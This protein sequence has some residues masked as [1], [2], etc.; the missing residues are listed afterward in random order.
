MSSGMYRLVR[1]GAL[2]MT[3]L[4][5]IG[6]GCPR[7]RPEDEIGWQVW[8]IRDALYLAPTVENTPAGGVLAIAV[9]SGTR[10][11]DQLGDRERFY[12]EPSASALDGEVW[13]V[14]GTSIADLWPGATRQF[15]LP[16]SS[17]DIEAH[18]PDWYGSGLGTIA[19]WIDQGPALTDIAGGSP[20]L[21]ADQRIFFSSKDGVVDCGVF[22]TTDRWAADRRVVFTGDATIRVIE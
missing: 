18:D 17:V 19:I 21:S 14:D 5:L 1:L 10:D 12:G 11:P 8:P 16:S 6:C 22:T 4:V 15:D 3:S 7:A 2:S 13:R 20:T 9:D